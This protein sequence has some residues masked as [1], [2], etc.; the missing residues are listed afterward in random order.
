[1]AD[2]KI[3]TALIL[4]ITLM[5]SVFSPVAYAAGE[6]A[7]LEPIIITKT[8]FEMQDGEYDAVVEGQLGSLAA[9]K[10]I[11]FAIRDDSQ[12]IVCLH[13]EPSRMQGRFSVKLHWNGI[14]LDKNYTVFVTDENG[15]T[16]TRS[17]DHGFYSKDYRELTDKI[18]TI[19]DLIAECTAIG[20]S[21]CEYE[22]LAAN[23]AE[24]MLPIINE[25][26]L[27]GDSTLYT[28][29][30]SGLNRILNEA[31][32]AL[33]GYLAGTRVQRKAEPFTVGDVTAE[34]GALYVDAEDGKKVVYLTGYHIFD[35]DLV[36]FA[37]LKKL[38][39]N[40]A[41]LEVTTGQCRENMG[42]IF[43]VPYG[44]HGP[45][46][47]DQTQYLICAEDTVVKDGKGSVKIASKGME[48]GIAQDLQLKANT[49]YEFGAEVLADTSGT[50]RL[51]EKSVPFSGSNQ[52]Q[53]IGG[54][55]TALADYQKG[56]SL[57][58]GGATEGI[59]ADNMYV[60]EVGSQ[61][62]LLINGDLERGKIVRS[63]NGKFCY[64]IET[65]W[66]DKVKLDLAEA[67][68]N[69]IAVCVALTPH[70][71][72]G[73]IDTVA[74][75]LS[76]TGYNHNGFVIYNPTDEVYNELLRAMYDTVVEELADCKALTQFMLANEPSFTASES[77]Y[78]LPKWQAFLEERYGTIGALNTAYGTSYTA[79]NQIA[80]PTEVSLTPIY[81]DYREFN[82]NLLTQTFAWQTAY[83]KEKAPHIETVVKT[84]QSNNYIKDQ[85]KNANHYENWAEFFDINGCDT[86]VYYNEEKNS[87]MIRGMWLDYL[88]SIKD[89]PIMDLEMHA[90]RDGDLADFNAIIPAWMETVL[91]HGA[92]HNVYSVT[93]WLFDGG[94]W[95]NFENTLLV[96][97]PECIAAIGGMN[98]DLNRL[99]TEIGVLQ[100]KQ[101]QIAM[102]Y[103]RENRDAMED[104]M[105]NMA[106]TYESVVTYGEKV[107][108]ILDSQ[109][110]KLN[111]GQYKLLLLRDTKVV[112]PEVLE[113]IDRFV[114]QGGKVI[115]IHSL[116]V[117]SKDLLAYNTN[118]SKHDTQT[119][120]TIKDASTILGIQEH[121]DSLKA[122]VLETV[123]KNVRLVDADGNDISDCEWSYTSY[124]MEYL[125]TITNYN[126]EESV[127]AY[128]EID[129][130]RVS[131]FTDLRT[132]TEYEESIT[133]SP[134]Q[135][136][137]LR[138]DFVKDTISL[139]S[140]M[141]TAAAQVSPT[142]QMDKALL[143]LALYKD[144]ALIDVKVAHVDA[145]KSEC[146]ATLEKELSEKGSY[147]VSRFLF[148]ENL[149]P[150]VEKEEKLFVIP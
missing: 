36:D 82:D 35:S 120:K 27:A 47:Q 8:F 53:Q 134:Y 69:G 132:M 46:G 13:Q 44:F 121:A 147:R 92:M 148:D 133:L 95:S 3:L 9:Y 142:E 57:S 65:S 128:L 18:S 110:E 23:V 29:Q 87:L 149:R 63:Q 71:L 129:G 30:I 131:A 113:E 107:D 109:P 97:R 140:N 104:Y 11:T 137:L 88:S 17:I 144:N 143:T 150:L 16:A 70:Y 119:V 98:Y 58:V 32:D 38:G 93:P 48:A 75:G 94:T 52:W 126:P 112:S 24:Y 64:N 106:E 108:F 67:E 10:N 42:L 51:G 102:Y 146:T 85:Y 54:T 124:G 1:M 145:S 100:G 86:M 135:P 31:I 72:P 7:I 12:A 96:N 118:G 21:D 91:W 105:L 26:Y 122:E 28:Y 20:M 130:E 115:L 49:V 59:Y 81:K 19:R 37:Q 6:S 22:E 111:S 25:N 55:F 15:N 41:T 50:I 33:N 34:N 40:H 116:N 2:K 101:A 74:P 4:C 103:S 141:L 90:L 83:L 139:S 78:Y 61:E 62:N 5:V 138:T 73:H 76:D 66:L 77:P 117:A 80:M 56:F 60:R 89:A 99:S 125:V 123:G 14:S 84:L 136:V 45:W 127:M 114:A 43:I 68:E 39:I 79:F